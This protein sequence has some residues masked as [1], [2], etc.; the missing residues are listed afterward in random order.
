MLHAVI[1]A[2]GSGTRFWPVSRNTLPKQLLPITGGKAMLEET[3]D[4][5]AGLIPD[6]RIWVV[7]NALQLDKV[8]KLCPQLKEDHILVEPFGRNT[9]ACVGLAA[10][11]ISQIDPEDTMVVLPADHLIR[12]KEAF[13][14]CLKAGANLAATPG[15]LVTFGVSPTH[16]A[17]GYGYIEKGA[18]TESPANSTAYQVASFK[19]KPDETTAA[20]FLATGNYLWNAGI[21]VWRADSILNAIETHMPALSKGISQLGKDFDDYQDQIADVYDNLESVPVDVGILEKSN[22]VQ[23]LEVN[24]QWSDVGSWKSLYELVAKDDNQN[25]SLFPSGGRLLT[26]DAKGILAYSDDRH[27]IAVLGLEN[28]IVVC[29]KDSVLVANRDDAE[30]VKKI[31]DQLKRDGSDHLL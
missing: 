28:I 19:E 14:E 23:V 10:V 16:P 22:Q 29:T 9:A 2:G 1:M 5:L 17:T 7:T 20:E 11:A 18:A 21:F 26:E 3:I 25:A 6:D 8:K 30:Q 4:R 13:Q 15:H 12:P 31:V 27:S 24:Y